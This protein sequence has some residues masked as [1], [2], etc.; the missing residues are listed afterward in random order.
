MNNNG[1]LSPS[2][3]MIEQMTDMDD[4]Q[5]LIIIRV[6]GSKAMVDWK[7]SRMRAHEALGLIRFVE[8]C[9]EKEIQSGYCKED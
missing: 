1:E 7:S 9:L 8:L 6:H 3:L 4:I 2:D 5:K